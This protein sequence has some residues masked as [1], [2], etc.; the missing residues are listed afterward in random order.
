M[1]SKKVVW[2]DRF[3]D[4]PEKAKLLYFYLISAADDDGF[5]DNIKWVSAMAGT[6]AKSLATLIEKEFVWAFCSG[7]VVI[8]HWRMQNHVPKDRYTPTLYQN[9]YS[10]L[11][12][13]SNGEYYLK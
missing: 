4:L 8:L 9:E 10:T 5:V 7:V 3:A 12:L 6:N 1:I 11:G 2:S 13:S